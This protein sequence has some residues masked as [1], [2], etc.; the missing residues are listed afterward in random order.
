MVKVLGIDTSNYTTSVAVVEENECIYDARRILN[1]ETGERGLRQSEA[2]FQHIKNL[3]ELLQSPY[4]NNLDAVCVSTRP[5]P[6]EGSYM[7]VFKA[8]ESIAESIANVAG[9]QL[10]RTTHQEG[11]IEAAFNSSIMVKTEENFVCIHL[12]GGTTE[13]LKVQRQR[14]QD[15]QQKMHIQSQVQ[16]QTKTQVQGQLYSHIK[17]KQNS[18]YTIEII[19]KT[20]DISAGQ[21]IDRIG[22]ALG[23]GFPCGRIMDELAMNCVGSKLRIPSK[24]D[25][26]DMNFSGQETL[27]LKYIKEG[28]NQEE[29]AYSLMLCI[30]KTLEKSICNINLKYNKPVLLTGGVASSNFI[31]RYL[32]SK[33]SKNLYFSKKELSADNAV[34]VA[35]IGYKHIMEGLL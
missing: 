7:P 2:L 35:F 11:H 18:D 1:V 31:K 23:Y 12:S 5:R 21:L 26:L 10:I 4:V 19:G 25:A 6:V 9:V 3:P 34:G 22:V 30:A 29:V 20:R 33:F 13:I 24:V 14:Q 15:Q 8:G 28:Y 17:G 32:N 27:C 16:T